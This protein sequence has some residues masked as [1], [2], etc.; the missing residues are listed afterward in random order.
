MIK[1]D[2]PRRT[3]NGEGKTMYIGMGVVTS[4]DALLLYLPTAKG[5]MRL[6]EKQHPALFKELVRALKSVG[7]K[8]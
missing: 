6:T 4:R 2:T 1:W 3:K 5:K 8:V 7:I